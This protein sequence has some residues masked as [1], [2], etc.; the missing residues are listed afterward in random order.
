M[1]KENYYNTLSIYDKGNGNVQIMLNK[2]DIT[3]GIEE[4]SILRNAE[5]YN[6]VILELKMVVIPD[7]VNIE[8]KKNSKSSN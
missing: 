6:T 1:K 8:F 7:K 5:D 3:P 2:Q 4:Y